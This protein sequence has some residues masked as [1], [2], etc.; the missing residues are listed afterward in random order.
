VIKVR[1]RQRSNG[2]AAHKRWPLRLRPRKGF[3]RISSRSA[4]REAKHQPEWLL[5]HSGLTLR[6]PDASLVTNV[7]PCAFRHQQGIF[8]L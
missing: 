3:T 1:L 7:G 6:P 4:G 8:D 2:A 5:L